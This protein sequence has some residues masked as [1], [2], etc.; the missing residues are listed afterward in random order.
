VRGEEQNQDGHRTSS[1]KDA[2]VLQCLG[3]MYRA[4]SDLSGLCINSY[5]SVGKV[6]ITFPYAVDHSCRGNGSQT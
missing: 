4:D 1:L 3:S 5:F 6:Q 2:L